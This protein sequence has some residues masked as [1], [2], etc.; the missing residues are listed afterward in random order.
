MPAFKIS[1]SPKRQSNKRLPRQL[2]ESYFGR[3]PSKHL[4]V[5]KCRSPEVTRG[6]H[7]NWEKVISG[8]YHPN[9]L[10]SRRVKVSKWHQAYTSLQCLPLHECFFNSTHGTYPP[11]MHSI[12]FRLPCHSQSK[13]PEA[14]SVEVSK[15]H[16]TH[17]S[18]VVTTQWRQ[19][20]TSDSGDCPPRDILAQHSKCWNI[21]TAKSILFIID[22]LFIR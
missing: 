19:A 10:K 8:D 21:V 17:P 14:R 18:V 20:T 13:T 6:C 12:H 5:Q 3:F 4:E 7:I 9:I 22:L 2:G 11:R 15:T 16:G 1:R